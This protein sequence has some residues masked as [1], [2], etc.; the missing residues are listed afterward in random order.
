MELLSEAECQ[1]WSQRCPSM[2]GDIL[3]AG[4]PKKEPRVLDLG[5]TLRSGCYFHL[6]PWEA[7]VE[8]TSL[9]PH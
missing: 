9:T 1:Q 2:K 7:E 8:V 6:R 5:L 4:K 3:T